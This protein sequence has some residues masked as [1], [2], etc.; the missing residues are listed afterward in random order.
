MC[1]RFEWIWF[2]SL[3]IVGYKQILAEETERAKRNDSEKNRKT[4]SQTGRG[5]SVSNMQLL[6]NVRNDIITERH[7][8]TFE[9]FEKFSGSARSNFIL[10]DINSVDLE[11]GDYIRGDL[12]SISTLQSLVAAGNFHKF[13]ILAK[14]VQS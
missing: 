14:S 9:E 1:K 3:A 4:L 10:P 7:E 11:L 6:D 12:L 5:F 8:S 13:S 2:L